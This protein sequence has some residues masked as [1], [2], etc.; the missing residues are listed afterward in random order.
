MGGCRAGELCRKM[1][2]VAQTQRWFRVNPE[3]GERAEI[4]RRLIAFGP[5][6]EG[7]SRVLMRALADMGEPA[8]AI[9]NLHDASARSA[10]FQCRTLCSDQGALWRHRK[11]SSRE[12]HASIDIAGETRIKR[13]PLL[14]NHSQIAHGCVSVCC[15]FGLILRGSDDLAVSLSEEVAADLARFVGYDVIAVFAVGAAGTFDATT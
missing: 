11:I 10:S 13:R 9:Q 4:A 1:S 7:A 8:Q 12:D 15:H 3:A 2:P 6:Y 5:T 14:R